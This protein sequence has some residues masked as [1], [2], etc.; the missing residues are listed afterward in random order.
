MLKILLQNHKMLEAWLKDEREFASQNSGRG[1]DQLGWIWSIAEDIERYT[2]KCEEYPYEIMT[3][4]TRVVT[5][6]RKRL[7]RTKAHAEKNGNK[8]ERYAEILSLLPDVDLPKV[9]EI[10]L[11][12]ETIDA[13]LSGLE[14]LKKQNEQW[15]QNIHP[16]N[17]DD[18]AAIDALADYHNQA[19]L[20]GR[21]ITALEPYKEG[22]SFLS[23]KRKG[24]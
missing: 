12:A 15:A 6:F 8:T 11:N 14:L 19:L 13:I 21:I 17:D 3:H 24:E 1:Y 16:R 20:C 22:E 9:R 4:E 2:R 10:A 5:L 18:D 23:Q 7:L